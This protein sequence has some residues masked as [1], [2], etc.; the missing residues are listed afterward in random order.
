MFEIL[1]FRLHEEFLERSH[2]ICFESLIENDFYYNLSNY[3]CLSLILNKY[4]NFGCFDCLIFYIYFVKNFA[5]FLDLEI[6]RESYFDKVIV[7]Y[8]YYTYLGVVCLNYFYCDCFCLVNSG[9]F[10]CTDKK[11]TCLSMFLW[12]VFIILL[13]LSTFSDLW[14]KLHHLLNDGLPLKFGFFS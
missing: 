5:N 10:T 9:L 7:V 3:F 12:F 1:L 11:F 2:E 4:F 13:F 6:F 8:I 14:Q